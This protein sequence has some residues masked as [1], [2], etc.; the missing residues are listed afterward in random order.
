MAMDYGSSRLFALT[1]AHRAV[2]DVK[3]DGFRQL[4]NY[5]DMCAVLAKSPMQSAFFERAQLMLEKTNSLYYSLIDRMISTIEED[6]LCTVGV[7]LGLGGLVYGAGR[8]KL[9][10]EK[11][12]RPFSWITTAL[13]GDPGLPDAVASAEKNGGYVWALYAPDGLSDSL[14]QLAK[15]HP[16]G[17][18][19]VML[20]PAQITDEVCGRIARV[21]NLVPVLILDAP[22]VNEAVFAAADAM[23]RARLFYSFV[24]QLDDATAMAA[25]QP[26]WLD[27]LSQR[28]VIGVYSRKGGMDPVVSE[29][30]KKG[31]YRSR[32]ELGAPLVLLDWEND[33]AVLDQ[34]IS[35]LA[36]PGSRVPAGVWTP[37]N[38]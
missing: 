34:H 29:T 25:L 8:L 15:K 3:K 4:R 16:M 38:G 21:N 22:E 24:L 33:V 17:V 23:R 37:L 5:V 1:L 11:D 9:K 18:F 13:A 6:R 32:T 10:A 2:G 28:G 7:N 30:L 35:P 12:G 26:E 31:I 20:A 19:F 14:L 36:V 27:V